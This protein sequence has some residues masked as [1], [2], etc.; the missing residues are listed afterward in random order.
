[1]TFPTAILLIL[2]VLAQAYSAGPI[3]G[4]SGA[5]GELNCTECHISHPLNSG[6]GS[7]SLSGPLSWVPGET[8]LLT[9][10]LQ[11]PGQQ[12]WGFEASQVGLGSFSIVD[13]VRTQWSTFEGREYVKHTIDGTSPRL[14]DGPSEW[15]FNWTAPEDP[16]LGTITLYAAGNA[17][18]YSEDPFGDYI[19]TTS[20]AIPVQ[21]PPPAAVADLSIQYSAGL[22]TLD[23]SLAAGATSYRVLHGSSPDALLPV[24]EV[25]APP[26]SYTV[27][28]HTGIYRIVAI[29]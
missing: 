9:V 11:D 10:T 28:V 22:V 25:A 20:L 4:V 1:M 18:D 5:P 13:P 8:Y 26:V 3:D 17:S 27:S 2:P 7:L 16:E 24:D 6:D 23:W 14:F 19:Y 21:L 29:N 12:R 15:S